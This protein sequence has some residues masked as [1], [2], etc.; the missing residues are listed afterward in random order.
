MEII[1]FLHKPSLVAFHSELE[2]ED[3]DY[4]RA[5]ELDM[6]NGG[7]AY[8]K[9]LAEKFYNVNK[10]L[11]N[12]KTGMFG[13]WY[14]ELNFKKQFVYNLISKH[15][16]IVHNMDNI[17]EAEFWALPE[18]V[19]LELAKNTTPPEVKEAILNNEAT[20]FKEVQELK[21]RLKAEQDEK[22]KLSRQLNESKQALDFALSAPP[23]VIEK[24]VILE[25][26]KHLQTIQELQQA[27]RETVRRL[28]DAE[29]EKERAE[30]EIKRYKATDAEYKAKEREIIEMQKQILEYKKH[31]EKNN[32]QMNALE[33]LMRFNKSTDE[34]IKSNFIDLSFQELTN[35]EFISEI[36]KETQKRFEMI[37]NWLQIHS[38]KLG[39]SY[40]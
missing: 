40:E 21:A 3:S 32:I 38:Q 8:K 15:D 5:E 29:L 14:E 17:Q 27:N 12:Y 36:K 30:L 20:T 4:I 35:N 22:E 10:R 9:L 24:E 2:K 34:F 33:A 26:P 11:A 1:E 37:N 23:K 16:Y 7:L 39:I 28:S 18:S 13:R 31:A 6:I 25:N 19:S